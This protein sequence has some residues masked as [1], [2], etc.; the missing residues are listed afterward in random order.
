MNII[1]K[2]NIELNSKYCS[3]CFSSRIDDLIFFFGKGKIKIWDLTNIFLTFYRKRWVLVGH[4]ENF[5]FFPLKSGAVIEAES[6]EFRS[7]GPKYAA[8]I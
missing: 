3:L 5:Y 7:I 6:L 8:G 2:A 4:V 1:V